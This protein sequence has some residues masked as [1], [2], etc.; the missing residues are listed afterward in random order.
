M[1]KTV[2]FIIGAALVAAIIVSTLVIFPVAAAVV[3]VGVWV[4]ALFGPDNQP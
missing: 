1:R 2:Q 4:W 3:L